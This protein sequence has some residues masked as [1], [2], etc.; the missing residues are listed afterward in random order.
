MAYSDNNNG[1]IKDIP[2]VPM[3]G[4]EGGLGLISGIVGRV[5]KAFLNTAKQYLRKPAIA[6]QTARKGTFK[7]FHRG[8]VTYD[9]KMI[10]DEFAKRFS[11]P[12]KHSQLTEAQKKAF[13]QSQHEYLNQ[14]MAA[15][16]VGSA[17]SRLQKT[18][19]NAIKEF[20]KK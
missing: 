10:N 20:Y 2:E 14:Q 8:G 6:Q 1:E 13:S 5:G 4:A 16:E 9:K 17:S 12:S 19:Q 3:L 15:R 11:T 18:H 7:P